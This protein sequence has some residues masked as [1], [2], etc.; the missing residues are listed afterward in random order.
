MEL[1][2]LGDQTPD[3]SKKKKYSNQHSM[4]LEQKQT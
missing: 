4:V 3:Y 1:D 2:E